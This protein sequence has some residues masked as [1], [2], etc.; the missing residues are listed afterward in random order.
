MS[1]PLWTPSPDR[2]AAANITRFA[3]AV[4]EEWGVE[5][6][7]YGALHRWSIEQP[8]QFWQSV[9]AF[10]GVI[11]EREDQTVLEDAD[12]PGSTSPRTCCARATMVRP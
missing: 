5:A 12:R 6:A 1:K 9:W 10:A 3:Q 4:R 2:V 8:E 7:D 11:A